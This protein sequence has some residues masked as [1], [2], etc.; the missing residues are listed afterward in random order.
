[1]TEAAVA[2]D[3]GEEALDDPAA[4]LDRKANLI[5][6]L[7]DDL[8]GNHG[9]LGDSIACVA[10]VGEDLLD[11][12]ER[13]TRRTQ[14][15]TTTVAILNTG[16]V[17]FEYK[18]APVGVDESMTLTPVDL[19]ARVVAARPTRLCRLDALAVDD[20][21]GRASLASNPL[22][23]LHDEGVI[24]GLKAPIVAE[25]RKPAIDRAP[26]RK[27]ARQQPPSAAGAHHV[28]DAVND[29]AHRPRSGS[30]F[31]PRFREMRFNHT[32]LLICQIAL[33]TLVLAAMLLSSGRGPHGESGLVSATSL[34]SHRPRP[35]NPFSKR[36]LRPNSS[37]LAASSALASTSAAGPGQCAPVTSCASS[38]K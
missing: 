32:P 37:R 22:A 28:K 14:Q 38:A 19:L 26:G 11:E 31:R 33:V 16:R 3:P 29:L 18:A 12:R 15:R 36:P 35:L 4:G 10:A 1:M 2:A 34:K 9:G 24:D 17:R 5:R 20:R 23:I 8:D 30:A 25:R 27:V 21:A 13:S 7:P 6:A